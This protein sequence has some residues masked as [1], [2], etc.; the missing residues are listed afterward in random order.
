MPIIYMSYILGYINTFVDD[1]ANP[2]DTSMCVCRLP[3]RMEEQYDEVYDYTRTV[4]VEYDDGSCDWFESPGECIPGFTPADASVIH[5]DF[6]M[7]N[8][9]VNS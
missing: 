1:S 3:T 4:E 2:S 6:L 9:A 8:T 7:N 5:Q